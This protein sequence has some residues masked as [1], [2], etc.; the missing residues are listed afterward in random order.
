[1]AELL[2]QGIIQHINIPFS[3]CVI[4]VKKKDFTWRLV[5]DYSLNALTKKGKY[6]L[7]VI[8]ELLDELLGACRFSKLDLRAGY[9][10]I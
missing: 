1:V 5:I 3:S 6:P 7:H 8:D 4:F 2:K 9:H 10:Q